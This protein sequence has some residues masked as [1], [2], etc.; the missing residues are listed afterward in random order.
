MSCPYFLVIEYRGHQLVIGLHRATLP[1][2]GKQLPL[3]QSGQISTHTY[4]RTLSG[5]L[6]RTL[7]FVSERDKATNSGNQLDSQCV[8]AWTTSAVSMVCHYPV[9][10]SCA[11]NLKPIPLVNRVE[12][13]NSM[14]RIGSSGEWPTPCMHRQ[15]H[16]Q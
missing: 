6:L 14:R 4:T 2:A 16:W 12:G 5:D 9:T 10:D 13:C 15:Y 7:V 1:F 8:L 11:C 3:C